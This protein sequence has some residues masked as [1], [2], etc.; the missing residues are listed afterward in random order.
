[1]IRKSPHSVSESNSAAPQADYS[2]LSREELERRLADA[3]KR[4]RGLEAEVKRRDQEEENC[5]KA[6]RDTLETIAALTFGMQE[7]AIIVEDVMAA[8]LAGT[9]ENVMQHFRNWVS[10]AKGFYSMT[11]MGGK[12]PD[13]G[14]GTGFGPPPGGTGGD[15]EGEP[16]GNG[17]EG[18]GTP[19]EDTGA[20][21]AKALGHIKDTNEKVGRARALMAEVIGELRDADPSITL[22]PEQLELIK[23]RPKKK[24]KGKS[25]G[26]KAKHRTPRR[27]HTSVDAAGGGCRKCGFPLKPMDGGAEEM[28]TSIVTCTGDISNMYSVVEGRFSFM[29]CTNPH[30]SHVHVFP[31]PKMDLP[32]V[33]NREIGIDI[34]IEIA[35]NVHQGM[36]LERS[37][38]VVNDRF[39]LGHATLQRNFHDFVRL[40]LWPQYE[41]IKDAMRN[42]R[43]LIVDGTPFDVQETFGRRRCARTKQAEEA[44][45]NAREAALQKGKS[46]VE[47][48]AD[49]KEAAD[50]VFKTS[51]SS[52]MLAVTSGPAEEVQFAYYAY[53][54]A[55][56]YE[57]IETVFSGKFKIEA[58]VTDGFG[59]YN[60][61]VNER[62]P[63]IVH[64]TCGMHIRRE[65]IKGGNLAA[66]AEMV[67]SL[68]TDKARDLIRQQCADGMPQLKLF[69]AYCCISGIYIQ[70]DTIEYGN[71]GWR[72]RL[73]TAR[74]NQRA[75]ADGLDA[76]MKDLAKDY[77]V[78]T[79]G[80]LWRSSKGASPISR[81]CVYYLNRAKKFRMFLDRDGIPLDSGKVERCIRPLT[82]FRKSVNF[83][84]S[85]EGAEDLCCVYSLWETAEK[86]R[87]E[88]FERWLRGYCRTLHVHA[89]ENQLT[90]ASIRDGWRPGKKIVTWDMKDLT[91]GF[92]FQ[93]WNIMTPEGRA[94][95]D[96]TS[97]VPP[98]KTTTGGAPP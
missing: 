90:T 46:T 10:W 4:N 85:V 33:P 38:E 23:L 92:D 6:F 91:D 21:V 84:V 13:L 94:R 1:M 48:D 8:H 51:K 74:A 78:Q 11:P 22:T 89:V 59:P 41:F 5:K 71:E 82:V 55:R 45:A 39:E 70:E 67:D 32:V 47:A 64:Q 43:V 7:H 44:E 24:C 42:S 36:P 27:R 37:M 25:P 34:M 88:N 28:L 29:N 52:Y 93:A 40:Y 35:R 81:P 57:N 49:G 76:V 63:G 19:E 58:L 56:T 54:G 60:R 62:F 68:D 17:N 50:K 20:K 73:A 14:S 96:E 75:L 69:E 2:A 87:M 15:S 79:D 80:G 66:Y 16:E 12:G 65:I 83:M 31:S 53:L 86:L 72:D 18:E 77:A 26:R 97:V 61:L 95:R 3:E 9:I 30:C 98:V